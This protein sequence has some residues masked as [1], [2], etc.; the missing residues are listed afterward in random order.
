ML[1]H[2]WSGKP[3]IWII[4]ALCLLPLQAVFSTNRQCPIPSTTGLHV[5]FPLRRCYMSYSLYDGVTCPIPSTTGLHVV[6]PLDAPR[7]PNHE[8]PRSNSL[9]VYLGCF[10]FSL[11]STC[12]QT[13]FCSHCRPS[14]KICAFTSFRLSSLSSCSHRLVLGPSSNTFHALGFWPVCSGCFSSSAWSSSAN[15]QIEGGC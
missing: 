12:L 9:P 11:F 10:F 5:L 6:L 7:V 14:N 13:F 2:R 1:N 4:I 8:N 3:W 15:H